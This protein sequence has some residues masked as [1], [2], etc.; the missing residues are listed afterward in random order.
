MLV[1]KPQLRGHVSRL[2]ITASSEF[3][4]TSRNC[5][6]ATYGQP[7]NKT[8]RILRGCLCLQAVIEQTLGPVDV[9]VQV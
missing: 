4:V 1:T 2:L 5:K 3:K 7:S 6:V 8:G 9:F